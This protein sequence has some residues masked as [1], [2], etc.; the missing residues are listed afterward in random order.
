MKMKKLLGCFLVLLLLMSCSGNNTEGVADAPTV[1]DPPNNE[2]DV[3]NAEW[4]VDTPENHGMNTDLL[5]NAADQVSKIAV[6]QGFVVIRDGVLIYEKYYYGDKDTKNIAYSVTKSFGA[7]LVGIAYTM[8][9]LDLDDPVSKWIDKPNSAISKN[10]TIRHLLTQTSKGDPPGSTFKYN[11]GAVVNTL[12]AIVSKASGM[13]SED[14][15]KK[16]LMDPIGITDYVWSPDNEGNVPFGA[17]ILASCRDLA[18][19][20]QM[21]LNGGTWKGKTIISKKFIDEAIKPQ[22]P[23]ANAGY[24]FLWWLNQDAGTWHTALGLLAKTGTGRM[25][26]GAP[27]NSYRAQGFFGQM[28]HVIPDLKIVAVSMGTTPNLE[29]WYTNNEFWEAIAPCMPK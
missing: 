26:P 8:G 2:A 1:T 10:A 21:Y 24:G 27:A 6:R 4:V 14:F 23:E 29:S 18:R 22:F 20:G 15:A 16:Y 7:T 17:G 28:I 25:I 9:L 5:N 3:D 19:L 12:S 13:K 11:S